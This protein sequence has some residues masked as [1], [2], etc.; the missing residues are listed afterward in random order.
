MCPFSKFVREFSENSHVLKMFGI[1][2]NAVSKNVPTFKKCSEISFFKDVQKNKKQMVAT[3]S[4]SLQRGRYNESICSSV[5]CATGVV[6]ESTHSWL[7]LC[8]GL[9][10]TQR[11]SHMTSRWLLRVCCVLPCAYMRSK[12]T[13]R[14]LNVDTMALFFLTFTHFLATS[15]ALHGSIQIRL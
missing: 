6:N 3:V 15:I 10:W 11:A 9:Y 2:K 7:A 1:L 5:L 4:C 14:C 8:L 12:G 13:L